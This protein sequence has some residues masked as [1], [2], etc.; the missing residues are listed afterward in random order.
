MFSEQQK[1]QSITIFSR[2]IL[3]S[4]S[5]FRLSVCLEILEENFGR[6]VKRRANE[7][8]VC[9][10]VNQIFSFLAF[11]REF[12]YC[13]SLFLTSKY[14]DGWNFGKIL[15]IPENSSSSS[16]ASGV[17]EYFSKSRSMNFWLWQKM[18]EMLRKLNYF[19]FVILKSIGCDFQ[20]FVNNRSIFYDRITWRFHFCTVHCFIILE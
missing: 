12:Y 20:K 4:L 10:S 19:T 14:L 9:L 8:I 18:K 16:F 11:R 6:R 13:I 15:S 2:G 7:S 17:R 1:N 3:K 5:I